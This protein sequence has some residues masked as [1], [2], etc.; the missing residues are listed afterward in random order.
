[1]SDWLPKPS[2][3]CEAV[4]PQ[5][6][7]LDL[8]WA[9]IPCSVPVVSIAGQ[10]NQ[11][12]NGYNM[13]TNHETP[14]ADSGRTGSVLLLNGPNLNLLG[15]RE[16]GVYGS[17]TLGSIEARIVELGVELG[18]S[19]RCA[20]SNSEGE[21]VDLVHG[22]RHG[23][24]LIINPGAYAHYSY[25]IRDAIASV[26]VPCIEIHMSNVHAREEFRHTSVISPVVNGFI[27]G[28]GSFGYELALRALINQLEGPSA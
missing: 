8:Y 18:V 1:M 22:A 13:S 5:G 20:Q 15:E 16:P 9:T 25:A 10:L 4:D 28:C 2:R 26:S 6:P 17:Q 14:L 12:R 11:L 3:R 23:Q 24:G 21:L 7:I 27:C 19:V